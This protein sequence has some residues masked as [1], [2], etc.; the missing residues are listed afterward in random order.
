[1]K[2]SGC[3]LCQ[4][5]RPKRPDAHADHRRDTVDCCPRLLIEV[6]ESGRRGRTG[7]R[8]DG[9]SGWFGS[10]G[11]RGSGIA[12]GRDRIVENAMAPKGPTLHGADSLGLK[13]GDDVKHNAWGEGVIL[14]IEGQGDKTEAV[15]NFPSV[16]EKR[17]LLAWAPLEK[18]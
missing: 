12:A 14:D 15:V 7:G 5:P 16:G 9:S 4:K 18:I 8:R 6:E 3:R 11:S 13:V 1:M 2:G 17:L 10:S